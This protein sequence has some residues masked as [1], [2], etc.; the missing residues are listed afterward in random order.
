MC[1]S[2]TGTEHLPIPYVINDVTILQNQNNYL[3]AKDSDKTFDCGSGHNDLF[4]ELHKVLFIRRRFKSYNRL[5]GG[6]C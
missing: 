5:V 4:C 2:L 6:F 3:F 1:S